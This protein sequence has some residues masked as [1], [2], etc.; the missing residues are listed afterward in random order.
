MSRIREVTESNETHVVKLFEKQVETWGTR[1]AP[2]RVYARR[3]SIFRAVAGMWGGLAQSGLI[4]PSLV[5]L[6][7]RRVA[8]LNGCVF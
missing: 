5:S 6:V 8:Q 4:D 1:L 2:Y 3:P 7:N